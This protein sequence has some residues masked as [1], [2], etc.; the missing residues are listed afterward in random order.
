MQPNKKIF[1]KQNVDKI[2]QKTDCDIFKNGSFNSIEFIYSVVFLSL[3]S[4]NRF[5][6]TIHENFLFCNIKLFMLYLTQKKINMLWKRIFRRKFF[7]WKWIFFVEKSRRE[8]SELFYLILNL[9]LIKLHNFP[10]PSPPK[11]I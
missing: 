3:M 8:F 1:A 4:S 9:S 5:G 2:K 10:L 11:I 6:C 7:I